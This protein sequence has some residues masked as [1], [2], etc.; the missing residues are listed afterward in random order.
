MATERI[1]IIVSERGS[2]VVRRNIED[3]GGGAT[4]AQ[5]AVQLLHRALV[6][7]GVGFSLGAAVSTL[8]SFSQEMSTVRAITGATEDQFQALREEAKRLGAETRF[9]ATQ[10]AE[11][12]TFLARA[13]F[14]TSQV[15]ASIDDTLRLAQAGALDLGS[16]ADIAS[17]ILTG[18]RMNAEEAG[19]VVDV[20]AFAANRSNTNVQQLGDGM[21]FVA[22]VAAGLRVSLEEAT[23]A[24]GALSDAGLQGSIAGT[25]LRRVLSE[26]E[27]PSARTTR[28]LRELGVTTDQVRVSQ[29]GLTNAL[30][31]LR[32]AGVDTALALE[33]FGDRG[34]PAFEV[35][36]ESIPKVRE[37]TDA[38]RESEG[39]ARQVAETMDDNLNGALLSVRSAVE[40][41][42]IAFGDLGAE[43]V[44]TQA[45]RGLATAIRF[46]ANNLDDLL[47]AAL[48]FAPLM[49]AIF[50][51]QI[52]GAI[53][54]ARNAMVA[55]TV[56]I[57][58]NPLGAMAVAISAI[59]S[60]LIF[61]KDEIRLSEDSLAS[62][63][64]LGR[65][66]W[67][68]LRAGLGLVIDFFR[69][70]FGLIAD[71]GSQV[72][73]DLSLSIEGV[74][75]FAARA[76]D[77]LIGLFVGAFKAIVAAWEGLPGAFIDIFTRAMNGAIRL[78]EDGVNA[79][80]GAINS[81]LEPV[82]IQ[83]MGL[84]NLGRIENS[85]A[86]GANR[87][88]AAVREGFLEGFDTR[89]VEGALDSTLARAEEIAR[90]RLA[91]DEARAAVLQAATNEL[92]AAQEDALARNGVGGGGSGR[93]GRGAGG[94]TFDEIL[95]GLRQEAELLQLDSRER[96]IQNAI[97]QVQ[98]QLKRELTVTEREMLEAQLRQ[99]QSLA[100]QARLLDEIRGPQEELEARMEALN[101][102]FRA[103]RVT[104]DEHNSKL[105]ELE[106][107]AL[108]AGKSLE[109]GL[110]RGLLKIQEQM[111][112]VASAAESALV[113][114]FR[115]AEDAL[116]KF[117]ATGKLDFKSLADSILA[118]I[119]RI[120]VRQAILG[121]L[122]N[123]L[124]GGG[125]FVS[126]GLLG[127]QHGGSFTVG[128]AGGVDS[129]LVAFRA[130]PG[131]RVTINKPGQEE[132]G[133]RQVIVNYYI[134]TPNAESFQRSQGQIMSRT[135]A[136][137][138]RFAVRNN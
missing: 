118:D 127:F 95:A 105:R 19:R 30:Q 98:N 48:A 86:G 49:V 96:E 43:S 10:A 135:Q 17:N 109:D 31:V 123:L 111:A 46:V 57:A 1:D 122:A 62:L 34:G 35:L 13:G 59:I 27:S 81:V 52:V 93:G 29:V 42:I 64:D 75:R 125:L 70:N 99:N 126:G 80:I 90:D 2:R 84:V 26:L 104:V 107:Q 108:S 22:P 54:A 87:L 3:I 131:E 18:F 85:A 65:A 113:N 78:V 102:L 76:A 20:L 28:I 138:S 137:L 124:G 115:S 15:L 73:G 16:A 25:G 6:T 4:R 69:D 32:D 12:M 67:E 37:M 132:G 58:A 55:L 11:G 103:G 130:T 45:F 36:S 128:G 119:T 114:A 47:Q 133:R 89:A 38:L 7:L 77:N 92:S 79:I 121:P 88:G 82:G 91:A 68:Q 40:A 129:Q 9:S 39:F 101:A 33:I 112:D 97:L 100:D 120:A 136:A 60:L 14:D 116:T 66:V 8:A 51:V 56:A 94:P 23:A 44:L 134:Q 21:K 63:G 106:I 72:L 41:L 50:R 61:F 24:V 74:L 71:F 117:V 110:R 83:G 53:M 5:G